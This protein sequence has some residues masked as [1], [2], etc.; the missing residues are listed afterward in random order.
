MEATNEMQVKE[1]K[2]NKKKYALG[3]KAFFKALALCF[4]GSSISIRRSIR[5][6]ACFLEQNDK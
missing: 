3:Q 5:V 1:K 6:R 4:Q 2:E